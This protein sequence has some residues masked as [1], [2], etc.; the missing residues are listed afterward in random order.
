MGRTLHSRP[1]FLQTP[2]FSCWSYR[3]NP[4]AWMSHWARDKSPK[5]LRC[6]FSF[7]TSSRITNHISLSS[8]ALELLGSRSP[9]PG[10]RNLPTRYICKHYFWIA[11]LPFF[12]FFFAAPDKL[13]SLMKTLSMPHLE[14]TPHTHTQFDPNF[15]PCTIFRI[16]SLLSLPDASLGTQPRSQWPRFLGNGH[17]I[18]RFQELPRARVNPITRPE[19][20]SQRSTILPSPHACTYAT[21]N[22]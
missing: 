9:C 10:H 8:D 2:P 12:F 7:F 5:G 11:P 16:V 17:S 13:A 3:E 22:H 19:I 18:W 4:A 21:G 1:W 14:F 20:G 15:T 6:V